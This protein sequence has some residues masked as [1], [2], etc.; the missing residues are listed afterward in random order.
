[1]TAARIVTAD[2]LIGHEITT[3][4][5]RELGE[6]EDVII[7]MADGAVAYVVMSRGGVMGLGEKYFAVPW[8]RLRVEEDRSI[9]LD[10]EPDVFDEALG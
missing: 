10:V 7:D 1:M 2:D 3:P 4:D 6:I 9:L 8:H 5:G